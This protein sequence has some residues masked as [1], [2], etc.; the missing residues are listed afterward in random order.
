MCDTGLLNYRINVLKN[1]LPFEDYVVV[2][3]DYYYCPYTGVE[4][5]VSTFDRIEVTGSSDTLPFN[6]A[7]YGLIGGVNDLLY[8]ANTTSQ[9]YTFTIYNQY[10]TYE[11]LVWDNIMPTP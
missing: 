2:N 6:F 10:A 3:S 11:L 8:S 9:N 7:V 1:D 4:T 5:A